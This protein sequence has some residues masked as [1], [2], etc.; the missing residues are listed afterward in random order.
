MASESVEALRDT[1]RRHELYIKAGGILR[2][3]R[4]A[5]DNTVDPPDPDAIS[6]AVWAVEGMLHEIHEI[7]DRARS[8]TVEGES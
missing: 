5:S 7:A 1:D 6:A 8:V 2:C 3:I 4:S